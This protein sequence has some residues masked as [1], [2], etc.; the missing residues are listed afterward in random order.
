MKVKYSDLTVVLLCLTFYEITILPH[1]FFLAFKYLVL[2]GVFLRYCKVRGNHYA[3]LGFLLLFGAV[4]GVS[5]ILNG[6][7]TNT[8]VASLM[9]AV[10]ILDIY[11]VCIYYIENR[12]IWGLVEIVMGT[13][14]ALLLVNDA[15]MLFVHYDFS[16][17]NEEY[18]IGNKFIVSY[19]HCFV[20]ALIFMMTN[21]E[22]VQTVAV[23]RGKI[24]IKRSTGLAIS[25]LFAVYS[26]LICAKVTCSTG[27]IS[28]IVL[29]CLM[30]IPGW[31]RVLI[32]S[33][34]IIIISAAVINILVLGSASI[35][36]LPFF[37]NIIYEVFG[38]SYT[39]TGRLLIWARIFE[40]FREAPLLGHGYYNSTV[41]DIVG[42]GNPQNGVLKI[43]ID[44]GVLG[45]ISYC[46]IVW[47]SFR[48]AKTGFLPG[49]YPLIAFTY[50]MIAASI[51]EINLTHM[52]VFM[53]MAIYYVEN[54]NVR[55]IAK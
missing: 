18:F 46:T 51:V 45:L 10:Q 42:F 52:I 3:I 1:S 50:A 5:S 15:L 33:N 9:F 25:I 12:S 19:V 22:G 29:L 28:C 48:T 40:L 38:K 27:M 39:W 53:A 20:S 26:I 17:P 49:L 16:S 13:F 54:T 24:Q 11:L 44:A 21:K 47:R 2:I 35:L 37:E 23:H 8:I 34:K 55:E 43:L 14:L 41:V 32:S 6:M 4:T 36:S 7:P 30:F 31:M